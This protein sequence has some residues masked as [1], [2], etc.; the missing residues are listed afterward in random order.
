[1]AKNS[2]LNDMNIINDQMKGL[3]FDQPAEFE[4]E[5]QMQFSVTNPMKIQGHIK[6]TVKGVAEEGSFEQVRRY[7]EFFALR[8]MLCLRWPGI[9][10]PAIPEKKRIG[11]K[12]DKFVEE[13]R[14]MLENF[15]KQVAKY[16]YILFS[17]EFKIFAND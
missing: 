15:L 10:I 13:R 9:Y 7:S 2:H 16:E 8:N 11:N 5:R 17:R 4:D 6:Y 12:D 3:N 14:S 1:M